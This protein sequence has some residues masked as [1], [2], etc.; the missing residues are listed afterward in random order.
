MSFFHNS[1]NLSKNYFQH[2]T[3]KNKKL[4]AV[5]SKKICNS[6]KISNI[7]RYVPESRDS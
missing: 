3:A 5:P 7:L 6:V 1:S 4:T 2:A